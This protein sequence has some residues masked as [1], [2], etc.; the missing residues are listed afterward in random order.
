VIVLCRVRRTHRSR[1]DNWQN[2]LEDALEPA[3]RNDDPLQPAIRGYVITTFS[4][5]AFSLAL[6]AATEAHVERLHAIRCVESVRR[7][8]FRDAWI[9]LEGKRGVGDFDFEFLRNWHKVK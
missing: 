2:W 9:L 7:I 5:G 6:I 4:R 3:Q 8:G 1:K